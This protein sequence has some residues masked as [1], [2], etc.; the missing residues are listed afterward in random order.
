[1]KNILSRRAVRYFLVTV[2]VLCFAW[3]GSKYGSVTGNET[4]LA[5]GGAAEE[6]CVSAGEGYRTD[7]GRMDKWAFLTGQTGRIIRAGRS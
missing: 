4:Q 3:C 7:V 2:A 5:G 1:M 6:E